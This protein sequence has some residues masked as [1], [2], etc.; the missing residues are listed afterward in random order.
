[1]LTPNVRGNAGCYRAF[2]VKAPEGS[3]LNCDKPM[4]VNLRTRTGW[5]IA[6][7]IFTALAKAA[8]GRVQAATGLPV[9]I[10]IYGRDAAGQIYSDHL[11][12]GGG[13]GGSEA[14]DGV[15]AL[16]WPTSAANTSIELLEQRVPV[17]V[18]EK[19][20][21]P[22]S[23]G[24][25]RHR[26]GLGQ[27]VSVR[28]LDGGRPADARLGL[29]R[30]RRH[31]GAGPVRR[32]ARP[33]RARRG[34]RCR[35]ARSSSIAAPASWSRPRPTRR[36]SRSAS[37]AAPASARRSSGRSPRSRAISPRATSRPKPPRATMAS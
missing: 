20:Y 3:A 12:M 21:V 9:A 2:T 29:S 10:T 8:P 32:Q 22:D 17:L 30:R 24:P 37:R 4:A 27:R 18:T 11:F 15:S 34:A 25:G 31:R 1:M 5:Y 33:F 7:N 6:P 16:L 28:K 19:A 13:Q 14:G 36:S 35:R 26:G 23:G